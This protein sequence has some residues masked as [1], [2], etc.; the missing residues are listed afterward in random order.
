MTLAE[1]IAALPPMPKSE[2]HKFTQKYN[3][4]SWVR[5]EDYDALAAR[6]AVLCEALRQMLDYKDFHDE[7]GDFCGCAWCSEARA[8]LTACEVKP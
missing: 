6:N 5:E 7:P 3:P 2:R 8:A 4:V 1:R